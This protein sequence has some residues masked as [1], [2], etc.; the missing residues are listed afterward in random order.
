MLV[1]KGDFIEIA[2]EMKI[3]HAVLRNKMKNDWQANS[4]LLQ[5]YCICEHCS[6]SFP[7]AS[8]SFASS[9]RV[10]QLIINF[11]GNG[12]TCQMENTTLRECNIQH[13]NEKVV[14]VS[15]S[16]HLVRQVGSGNTSKAV[17]RERRGPKQAAR[18]MSHRGTPV[19]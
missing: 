10:T 17:F 11:L 3:R 5:W 4:S 19:L 8:P 2:S 9:P 16:P 7:F 13:R 14:Q 1:A 15:F 18:P 6:S 12:Q